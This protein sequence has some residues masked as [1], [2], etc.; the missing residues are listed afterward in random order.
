VGR[1]AGIREFT[2]AA[3]IPFKAA[4][5]MLVAASLQTY[6]LLLEYTRLM[7]EDRDAWSFGADIIGDGIEEEPVVALRGQKRA[8]RVE[9]EQ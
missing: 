2:A 5:L 4:R 8:A 9:R 1:H 3:R 7:A 6:R